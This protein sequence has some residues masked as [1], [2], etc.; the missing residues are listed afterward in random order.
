[1]VKVREPRNDADVRGNRPVGVAAKGQIFDQALAQRV[2]RS[3]QIAVERTRPPPNQEFN[4]D[5]ATAVAIRRR[6]IEFN[7]SFCCEQSHHRERSEAPC[8]L[9]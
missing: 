3:S 9:V 8:L 4:I 7:A 5:R 2:I 1:M 6:R